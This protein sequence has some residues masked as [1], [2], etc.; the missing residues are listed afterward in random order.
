MYGDYPQII[1]RRMDSNMMLIPKRSVIA[2]RKRL[3]L[4]LGQQLVTNAIY[5][6]DR[7]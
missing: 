6:V 2:T 5:T 7:K 3:T 4:R 1:A